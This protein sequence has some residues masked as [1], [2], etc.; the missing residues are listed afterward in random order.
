MT[1]S[2]LSN[3]YV[4]K[5]SKIMDEKVEAIKNHVLKGMPG[6]SIRYQYANGFHKFRIE[7]E[8]PTHWLYF[9]EVVVDDSDPVVL[10]NLIN[11]YHIVDTLVQADS[12]KWLFLQT[13]GIQ[14]VDENFAK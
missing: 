11:I 9:S 2:R 3:C 1:R 14:E 8:R 13:S 4:D 5:G 6:R 12:S 7:G 10:I